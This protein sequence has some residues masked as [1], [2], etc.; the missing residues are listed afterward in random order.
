MT[1]PCSNRF[2]LA[3]AALL[4]LWTGAAIAQSGRSTSQALVPAQFNR[5]VQD[6]MGFQW[7]VN[8]QGAIQSGTN[9]CFSSAGQLLVNGSSFSPSQQMMTADGMEYVLTRTQSGVQVTRR[10]RIDVKSAT[11]RYVE[12]F[13]NP[14][15]T[16][17]TLDVKIMTSLRTSVSSVITDTGRPVSSSSGGRPMLPSMPGSPRL[18]SYVGAPVLGEKDCGLLV[19][20]SST[21]YP[22]VLIYLAG[23]RSKLRPTLQRQSS[24][25]FLFTYPVTVPPKKT[26]SIV[27]GLAQRNIGGT[28]DPKTLAN[29]FKPFQSRDWTRNLPLAVRR[30]ILNAG[31]SAYAEETPRSPLLQPVMNL[32]D[33]W[34]VQRGKTDVLVQDEQTRVSGA[35]R[36]SSLTVETPFGKTAVPLGEVALLLGGGGIGR[37]Q[38]VHLRNGEVLV[39]TVGAGELTLEAES[40]LEVELTPKQINLLFMHADPAD[41]KP[42]P[43]AVAL[44][45][46]HHGD[47]LALAAD[48]PSK[49][50]AA[51]AWGP[52]EVPLAEIHYLYPIR[53]PQPIHR[54]ILNNKSRLSVIL[55]GSELELATLRFGPVKLAPG[56]IARLASVK[57]AGPSEQPGEDDDQQ[58]LKV[59]HCRLLGGNLL[60]GTVAAARLDLLTPAG[61]TP[62]DAR[63]LRLVERQD[64][65]QQGPNP[66]FSI[67]LANGT[68]LVG[69]FRDG[70]FPLRALGKVWKLP[71][72]HVL[73]FRRPEQ[74]PEEAGPGENKKAASSAKPKR[75]PAE[76]PPAPPPNP[77]ADDPFRDRP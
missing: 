29:Y 12:S 21:S 18:L 28:P 2:R 47:Q 16:P 26:V 62:V 60:V 31:R 17:V 64:E 22:A 41:G 14:Q 20:R 46:T 75:G 40:G 66:A 50:R 38:R 53:E 61:L 8:Q 58:Q 73:A 49:I 42:P 35:V 52:I 4:V 24:Y 36:G 30:S 3:V 63:L 56:A 33:R 74:T 51:T 19:T 68:S 34:D 43:K 15:T 67:E 23:P 59:P 57:A 55:G 72:H 48:S 44:L 27:H 5:N 54:L 39:G 65:D 77:P 9:R 71:V 11:L 45:K 25:R 1:K 76:K 69:R 32:A 6:A 7:D 13:H 10:V 37:T 70:V